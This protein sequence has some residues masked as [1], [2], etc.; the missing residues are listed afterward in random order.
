MNS[1]FDEPSD[2]MVARKHHSR[3]VQGEIGNAELRRIDVEIHIDT[4]VSA[5]ATD[6]VVTAGG[7]RNSSDL[8]VWADG[9]L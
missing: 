9:A 4:H 8:D 7:E 5:V 6:V 1:S 2:R 3:L